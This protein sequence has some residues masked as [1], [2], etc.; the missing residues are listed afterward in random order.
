GLGWRDPRR[1]PLW[2]GIGLLAVAYAL[3][4]LDERGVL[5]APDSPL[6][7]HAAWHTL[8]AISA[9]MLVLHYAA[10]PGMRARVSPGRPSD[11]PSHDSR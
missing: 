8:T 4:V 3:W 2:T 6:Q 9:L 1:A 5:C 10:A 7:G 11:S